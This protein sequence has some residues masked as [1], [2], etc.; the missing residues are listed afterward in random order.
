MKRP[1]ISIAALPS[2]ALAHGSHAPANSDAH[3]SLLHAVMSFEG[4]LLMAAIAATVYF[5]WVKK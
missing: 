5:V 4:A 2:F 3:H 1:L